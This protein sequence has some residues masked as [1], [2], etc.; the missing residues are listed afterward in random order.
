MMMLPLSLSP[1]PRK[2]SIPRSETDALLSVTWSG[3]CCKHVQTTYRWTQT[4]SANTWGLTAFPTSGPVK[5]SP[6]PDR[7][8]SDD[9][10]RS[11]NSPHPKTVN[12]RNREVFTFELTATMWRPFES[13]SVLMWEFSAHPANIERK[14]KYRKATSASTADWFLSVSSVTLAESPGMTLDHE[15]GQKV[16][17]G[18]IISKIIADRWQ[19]FHQYKGSVYPRSPSLFHSLL[20]P[21]CEMGCLLYALRAL[22]L[23]VHKTWNQLMRLIFHR[24]HKSVFL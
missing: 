21:A 22:K 12:K 11:F 7:K 18:M 3:K 5:S 1:P 8:D 16:K 15:I 10:Q 20:F 6:S 4:W 23:C 19:L 9:I 17:T 14:W 13:P 2:L 24:E